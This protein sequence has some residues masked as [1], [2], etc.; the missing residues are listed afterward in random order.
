[1]RRFITIFALAAVAGGCSA[2][3]IGDGAATSI[4][5][6]C[7]LLTLTEASAALGQSGELMEYRSASRCRFAGSGQELSLETGSAAAF[8]ALAR[9]AGAVPLSGIGQKALWLHDADGTY[10]YILKGGNVVTM[11]LPQ[12]MS[13]MPPAVAKAAELVAGRM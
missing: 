5:D 4:T 6:P 3:R 1:M 12:T 8:R 7:A 9:K 10:L 2:S 13:T 11:G